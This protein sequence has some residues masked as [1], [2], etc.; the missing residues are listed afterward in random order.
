[1]PSYNPGPKL[2]EV[3]TEV[4]RCFRPLWVIVD[5]STDGSAAPL[6]EIARQREGFEIFELPKN[7]GKGAAILH[8]LREAH[9]RG[10][11]GALTMDCDGQHSAAHIHALMQQSLHHPGAMILGNPVFDESAPWERLAGRRI[12]NFWMNLCTLWGGIPD[13]LFGMRVYPVEP[14]LEI[15]EI[16]TPFARRFDFDNEIAVRLFWQD[17]P[18]VSVDV[19]CYYLNRDEGQVSH[20]N[21]F[22]DNI[23]TVWMHLRLVSEALIRLPVLLSKRLQRTGAFRRESPSVPLTRHAHEG[24]AAG[25]KAPSRHAD[26]P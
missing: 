23:R 16:R 6:H 19:P 14:A 11:T 13:G 21:Y 9:G 18:P 22:W 20:Y 26:G 10:F 7:H 5:G 3:V 25:P 12:S 24:L 8:G 17:V 15:L 1:M 2:L 4:L